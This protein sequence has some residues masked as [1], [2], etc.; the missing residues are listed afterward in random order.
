MKKL[1]A[2]WCLISFFSLWSYSTPGNK[3]YK[4]TL[5]SPDKKLSAVLFLQPDGSLQYS[6][7]L[8]KSKKITTVIENS[9]LGIKTNL[10]D[11]SKG[12]KFFN[13]S[14]VEVV[15]DN[16][17]M[18][19]GKQIKIQ[20]TATQQKI[21]FQDSKN[22]SIT[23]VFRVYN[24]GVAYKYLISNKKGENLLKVNEELSGFKIPLPGKAWIAPYDSVAAWAPA[25]ETDYFSDIPIG[26]P[27]PKTVGWAFPALFHSSDNW[28]L[29]TEA[30]LDS[31]YCGSHLQQKCEKGLYK[32]RFPEATEAMGLGTVSPVSSSTIATPWRLII[33]GSSPAAIIENNLIYSLSKPASSQDLSWIKPG[34]AS[35]SWWSDHDSPRNIDKI[36]PFVD[37]AAQMGWEYSLVDANWNIMINGNIEELIKYADSKGIGLLLWY[38]SG[39]NHNSITEQ[40]RNIMNDAVKR[41][42]EMAKLEKWGIKGI[43]VDFFQSDKPFMIRLYEDILKDAAKHHLLVDFHGC[44]LPRGWSRTYPNLMSMEAVR[45]AEQYSWDTIF[46]NNAAKFNTI[47][48]FTRN[49]VGP[50]DYTPVTFTNYVV[51]HTTTSAH[52]LALSVVFESGL[53]H[54]ADRVSGYTS[55]P[56]FASDFLKKVPVVWDETLYISGEPGKDIVLAR[57]NGEVWYIAGLNGELSNKTLNVT[58]PFLNKGNYQLN[59]ISDGDNSGAFHF[60]QNDYK[61]GDTFTVKMLGKGGFA[62][63]LVKK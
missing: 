53:L 63:T 32:I 6:V 2:L 12:L 42:A 28:I 51:P 15:K 40:P 35:W 37:L 27:S 1:L 33:V 34:R 58:L 52:E 11:F 41:D 55:L 50:M 7:Q 49:A 31:T 4:W 43:K 61:P 17:N 18:L 22:G 48:P 3:S 23:L 21:S 29:L 56:L 62:A 5:F 57:R 45:G 38:N 25:Y 13:A 16:Y 60:T 46:A 47:L 59:L 9:S 30:G 19:I 39:G 8:E 20:S 26:T 14:A 54:L 44:T 10:H 24:D 36:K